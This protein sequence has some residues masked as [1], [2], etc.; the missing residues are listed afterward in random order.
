M[1]SADKFLDSAT[2]GPTE[3]DSDMLTAADRTS[4]S[5]N[6]LQ[7]ALGIHAKHPGYDWT[8]TNP[9]ANATEHVLFARSVDW[10]TTPLGPMKSWSPQL[11]YTANL[12]MATPTP[13]LVLW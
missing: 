6:F 10:S 1:N 13:A 11:K 12:L 2:N 9:P 7:Q 5:T 8:S 4:A 3:V